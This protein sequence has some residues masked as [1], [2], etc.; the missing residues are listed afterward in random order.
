MA[1]PLSKTEALADPLWFDHFCFVG[2]GDHFFQFNY[3]PEQDCQTVLPLQVT[4]QHHTNEKQSSVSCSCC[5]MTTMVVSPTGLS[6]N[7]WQ[8]SKET[9]GSIL[10][11]WPSVWL[12]TV[13]PPVSRMLWTPLASPPCITTSGTILFSFSVLSNMKEHFGDIKSWWL[14][15]CRE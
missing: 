11:D 8:T 10:T 7:T 12:L 1:L 15:T 2:M 3:T 6:G 5:T 9:D 4:K 13:P 14:Q